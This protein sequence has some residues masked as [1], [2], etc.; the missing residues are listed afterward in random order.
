MIDPI[1]HA[2][3]IVA[4]LGESHGAWDQQTCLSACEHAARQLAEAGDGRLRAII[5]RAWANASRTVTGDGQTA[6]LHRDCKAWLACRA[7]VT[8]FI[9]NH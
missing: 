8:R 3:G 4:R 7:R 6:D 5:D 1:T 9:N 2:R